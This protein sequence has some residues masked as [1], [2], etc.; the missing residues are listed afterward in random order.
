MADSKGK[1]AKKKSELMRILRQLAKNKLAVLGLAIMVI[2]IVLA[3]L[4]PK[5]IP[6]D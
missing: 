4:A 3:L 2:E 6:Y 1:K 5:I